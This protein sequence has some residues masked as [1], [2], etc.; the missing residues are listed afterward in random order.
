M[1][2]NPK[3]SSS[4]SHIFDTLPHKDSVNNNKY[5][6]PSSTKK[7]LKGKKGVNLLGVFQHTIFSVLSKN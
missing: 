1:F 5:N 6:F 4:S 2:V 3:Y 7:G